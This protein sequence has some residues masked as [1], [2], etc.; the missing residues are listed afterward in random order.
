MEELRLLGTAT[1]YVSIAVIVAITFYKG[2]PRFIDIYIAAQE[3]IRRDL[4]AR[5]KDLETTIDTE[6]KECAEKIENLWDRIEKMRQIVNH[7]LANRAVTLPPPHTL[8]PMAH[9]L[10]QSFQLP[11][12]IAAAVEEMNRMPPVTGL[13][14]TPKPAE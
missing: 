3:N 5:V 13:S 14:G 10:D 9:I 7:L 6:R 2:L 4:S 12:E 8:N 11:A 1:S